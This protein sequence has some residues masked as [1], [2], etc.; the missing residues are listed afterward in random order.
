MLVHLS[1]LSFKSNLEL[2]EGYQRARKA[3][4][5][6]RL[7]WKVNLIEDREVDEFDNNGHTHFLLS[8]YNDKVIGG[9]RMA[10]SLSPN[11]TYDVFTKYFG[12]LPIQRDR[13]LLETSRFGL[14]VTPQMTSQVLR[15]QT[16]ELFI[17]VLKFGL[18]EGYKQI[19]T[20]ID[21]RMERTLRLAGWPV[22]RITE[23]VQIGDTRT[24]VGILPINIDILYHLEEK[25][26]SNETNMTVNHS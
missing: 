14:E 25:K 24:I 23:V 4:F 2:V 18:Q 22:E 1:P 6:D 12:E 17:G 8:I 20:V 7:N 21:V 3:I 11:L 9:V 19:I 5:Y 15:D 26:A 16:I 10:S 13:Y